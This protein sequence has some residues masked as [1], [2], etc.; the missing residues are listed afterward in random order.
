MKQERVVFVIPSALKRALKARAADLGV[1]MRLM[2][3]HCI[4]Q[5]VGDTW[6]NEDGYRIT[7]PGEQRLLPEGEL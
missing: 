4:E 5:E 7:L 3:I 2:L 1:S 6:R